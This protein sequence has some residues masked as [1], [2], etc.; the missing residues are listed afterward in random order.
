MTGKLKKILGLS[1]FLAL[2]AGIV[3]YYLYYKPSAT[4]I[5]KSLGLYTGDPLYDN[6][7]DAMISTALASGGSIS[8]GNLEWELNEAAIRMANPSSMPEDYWRI[9]G[10][11]VPCGALLCAID[12]THDS[13][14]GSPDLTHTVYYDSNGNVTTNTEHYSDNDNEDGWVTSEEV[15]NTNTGVGEGYIPTSS[16][17]AL[18]GQFNDLKHYVETFN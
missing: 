17:S 9:D 3:W 11:V 18:W 8:S 1:A 7:L 15:A 14:S 6:A 13:Q 2:V 12:V 10:Q 5:A 4:A 16:L